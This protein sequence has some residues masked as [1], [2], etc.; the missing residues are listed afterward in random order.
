MTKETG[1]S[2]ST[3]SNTLKGQG[4]KEADEERAARLQE[5]G[6]SVREI[7]QKLGKSKTT[8]QRLLKAYGQREKTE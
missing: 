4:R 6:L 2:E 5:K 7:A 1:Y 3:I 8:V